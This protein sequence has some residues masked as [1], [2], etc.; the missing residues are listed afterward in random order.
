MMITNPPES[1]STQPLIRRIEIILLALI[2]LNILEF[3]E[4]VALTVRH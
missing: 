2:I 1:S 3:I 4:I